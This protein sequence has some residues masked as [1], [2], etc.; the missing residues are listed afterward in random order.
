[1]E[2]TKYIWLN[3]ELIEWDEANTHVL[4]HG[5][6]YGSSV[7]EGLRFYN[8]PQGPAVFRLEDHTKRLFYSAKTI[9][10]T[11]EY[12]E[13]EI[14]NAVIQVVKDNELESGYIRPLIYYGYGKM[15]LNPVGAKADYLVAAWPWGKYLSG[16]TIKCCISNYIR[17]HPKSVVADAKVSGYYSNSILASLDSTNRGFDEAILLDYE[18]NVAEGPGENLF[19]VK[20]GKLITPKEGTFCQDLQGQQ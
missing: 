10:I 2:T 8:T 20:N 18:G 19:M 1:M 5:L 11:P 7:F 16:D 3:G 14:N 12:S 17:I 13:E 6:H 9:G 15:G 4:T